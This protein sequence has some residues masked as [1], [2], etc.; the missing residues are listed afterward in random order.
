MRNDRIAQN[1]KKATQRSKILKNKPKDSVM[2]SSS[3]PKE[4]LSEQR[5]D[6]LALAT[7]R[8][9]TWNV[10]NMQRINPNSKRW[11]YYDISGSGTWKY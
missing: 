9:D 8:D 4:L 7:I 1:I 6:P 11:N 2:F 5:N 10:L 3:K